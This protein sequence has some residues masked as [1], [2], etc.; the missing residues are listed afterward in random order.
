VDRN[1]ILMRQTDFTRKELITFIKDGGGGDP[2]CFYINELVVLF[3]QGD[4]E[5]GKFL[6]SL[7]QDPQL[8]IE[9]RYPAYA[10]LS[11]VPNPNKEILQVL[12]E[13]RSKPENQMVVKAA[14]RHIQDAKGILS[15]IV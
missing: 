2:P 13:F 10:G 3:W 8:S 6:C 11:S 9:G 12:E 7:L 5:A 15:Q 14:Q 4:G 1:T